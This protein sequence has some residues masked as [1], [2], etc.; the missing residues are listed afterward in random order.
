MKMFFVN[1]YAVAMFGSQCISGLS[2]HLQKTS[3]PMQRLIIYRLYDAVEQHP[4]EQHGTSTIRNSAMNSS[5][6]YTA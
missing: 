1:H 3:L 2:P 4:T 6:L 5:R